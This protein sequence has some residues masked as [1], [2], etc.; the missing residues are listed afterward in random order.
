MMNE[1]YIFQLNRSAGG[2]PKL[3]TDEALLT[4]LGL[5][6]DYQAK[7]KIHGGPER[8]LCL[9]ALELIEQLQAEGHPIFPGSVGE[10][11]TIAEL[12][13]PA[14]EP[15]SRLA[16]GAEA[17]IEISSYTNPCP[18][19]AASFSDGVYGRISQK[20]HPG[21]SRLYAR[22]IKTGRLAAGQAVRVL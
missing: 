20:L 10:N 19:I 17:I 14:L 4:D 1:G 12:D 5:A 9:Y 18:T 2:V 13:W 16:L 3:A 6:G 11:V 21:W 15:G 22:I 8:A 7:R